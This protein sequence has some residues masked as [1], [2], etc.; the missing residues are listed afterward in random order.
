M[1]I[2]IV[3]KFRAIENR[4]KNDTQRAYDACV[5]QTSYARHMA[6]TGDVTETDKSIVRQWLTGVF[7][8]RFRSGSF[9][10][11]VTTARIGNRGRTAMIYSL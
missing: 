10:K 2:N 4:H 6:L 8:C 7:N 5:C 11:R 3:D 1:S 9:G